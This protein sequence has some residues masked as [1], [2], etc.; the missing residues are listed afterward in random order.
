MTCSYRLRE[1]QE[2]AIEILLELSGRWVVPAVVSL[3]STLQC[4]DEGD[5]IGRS[6]NLLLSGQN[7]YKEEI[8]LGDDEERQQFLEPFAEVIAATVLRGDEKRARLGY[9]HYSFSI[10][11]RLTPPTLMKVIKEILI[12]AALQKENWR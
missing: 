1:A 8:V 6:A 11:T 4:G 10:L 7:Q 5:E 9:R 2:V 3:V 12:P